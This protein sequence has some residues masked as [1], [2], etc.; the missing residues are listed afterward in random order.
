MWVQSPGLG[1]APA[2]RAPRRTSAVGL[3]VGT[4]GKVGKGGADNG[5]TGAVGMLEAGMILGWQSG[6][7]VEMRRRVV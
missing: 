7:G 6:E 2:S 3:S 1:G 4:R 5:P